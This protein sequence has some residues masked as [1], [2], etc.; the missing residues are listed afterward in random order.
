MLRPYAWINRNMVF[1]S[2]H[3]GFRCLSTEIFLSV[4]SGYGTLTIIWNLER[5]SLR[6]IPK[7]IEGEIKTVG[8]KLSK[9]FRII[10]FLSDFGFVSISLTKL[11][12]EILFLINCNWEYDVVWIMP[13]SF[14][15]TERR[16]SI[17]FAIW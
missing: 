12:L 5:S 10:S 3:L 4:K 15:C 1:H 8:F 13:L 2:Y 9:C 14:L 11:F 7:Y 16:L 6:S 17:T